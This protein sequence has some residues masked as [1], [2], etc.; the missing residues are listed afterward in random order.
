MSTSVFEAPQLT[1]PWKLVTYMK[2]FGQQAYFVNLPSKFLSADGRRA[3]L[4][5][6]ANFAPNW[7]NVSIAADPSGSHYGLVLQEILLPN[8]NE[9]KALA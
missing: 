4:C 7:N 1:G 9:A 2:D 3:W 5:Y 6:S 8:L